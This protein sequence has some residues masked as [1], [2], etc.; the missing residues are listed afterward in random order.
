MGVQ[1]GPEYALDHGV[2]SS[3]ETVNITIS[4][5]NVTVIN[6]VKKCKFKT[7]SNYSRPQ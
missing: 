3:P 6:E 4:H 1:I 2:T 7:S 5:V